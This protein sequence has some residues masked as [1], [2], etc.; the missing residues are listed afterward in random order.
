M[1][2]PQPVTAAQTY[3]VKQGETEIGPLTLSQINRMRSLGQLAAD[4]PCRPRDATDYQPL[5]AHFPHLAERPRKSREE[6]RKEARVLEGNGLANTALVCG[7]LSWVIATP[8]LSIFAMV[9]GAKSYL[10]AQRIAG[11]LGALSGVLAFMVWLA[12]FMNL[13]PEQ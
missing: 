1:M 12:R 3:F 8:I 13:I 4:S 5:A 10:F 7:V 6:H 9:L 11:L 2:K